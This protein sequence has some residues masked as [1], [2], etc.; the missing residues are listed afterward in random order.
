MNDKKVSIVVPIFGVEKYIKKCAI[1]LFNQTYKNCEFVFVNDKTKDN[2]M[3]I[4]NTL[5]SDY[6]HLENNIV[7][8]NHD[9]N[10]G[11]AAARNTGVQAATGL[12]VMHVD[13]D[14][15]IEPTTVEKCINIAIKENADAVI[16]GMLH[17]M[18][19]KSYV[20]HVSI[21]ESKKEYIKQ[22][23]TRS[24]NVCLCGGLYKKTLYTENN[25]WAIPGLNMGED[26]STKPRILYYANKIV[27][28]DEALY[29]Y[30]HLNEHSYT[31]HFNYKHIVDVT[32]AV[33]VLKTFFEELIDGVQFKSDLQEAALK[34]KILLLKSWGLAKS[35]DVKLEEISCIYADLPS[36]LIKSIDGHILL[37]LSKYHCSNLVRLF[38]KSG[39]YIKS[40]LK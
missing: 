17:V 25:V 23:L 5:L 11:L 31:Q 18:K 22:L 7:I 37:L 15:A 29:I 10:K 19:N 6:K 40:L 2:S 30:N 28:L 36:S 12:Y 3:K 35:S 38:V 32:K 20:E 16:F 27:G 39:F 26:Y 9:I 21:P 24:N 8:I 33:D 34:S 14:D 4:L 1:S 13:S